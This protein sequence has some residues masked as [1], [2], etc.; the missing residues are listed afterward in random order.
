MVKR[1]LPSRK[2]SAFTMIELIF[3]IVVI[4]ITVLSLPMMTQVN[5]R[6]MESGFVQEAIFASSAE[7]HQ[8]LSYRWD[9]N[10]APGLNNASLS[11]V[12]HIATGI[13]NGDCNVA[14]GKRRGHAA[15]QCN[16]GATNVANTAD[17]AV[18]NINNAVKNANLFLIDAA[19]NGSGYKLQNVTIT[20]AVTNPTSFGVANNANIKR[21]D[22]T[23]RDTNNDIVTT[24]YSYSFNLGEVDPIKRSF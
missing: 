15:R 8:A 17:A 21:V 16:M 12:I 18:P 1:I 20:L 22:A 24:L 10:S 4:A 2:R 3:A 7:I 19:D 14:T 6:G 5:A 11:E 23:I 9:R 13:A